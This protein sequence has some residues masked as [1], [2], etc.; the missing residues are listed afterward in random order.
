MD[1]REAKNSFIMNLYEGQ[2]PNKDCWQKKIDPR[3]SKNIFMMNL[4]EVYQFKVDRLYSINK[5][6]NGRIYTR[7][8]V[9]NIS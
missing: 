5:V 9:V 7:Y 8:I 1:P 6:I 4:Y 3:E 2:A